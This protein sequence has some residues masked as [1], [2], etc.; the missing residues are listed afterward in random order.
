MQIFFRKQS[1][2]WLVVLVFSGGFFASAYAQTSQDS[3]TPT[4]EDVLKVRV[5]GQERRRLT[6][7]VQWQILDLA[8]Q[9][10]GR[11]YDLA[12][13]EHTRRPYGAAKQLQELGDEG[14]VIW[15]GAIPRREETMRA[16]YIPN[17]SGLVSYWNFFVHEEN[18]Q[19]LA[20]AETLDDLKDYAFLLG[21][22]FQVTPFIE[23]EGIEVRFGDA[24]NVPR[25]LAS[26]RADIFMYPAIFRETLDR[27]GADEFDMVHLPNVMLHLPMAFYFFVAQTGSEELHSAI[28]TGMTNAKLDGSYETLLSTHPFTR[29][30]F[31]EIMNGDYSLIEF[32]NP[33]LTEE[34]RN[35]LEANRK[36]LGR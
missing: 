5:L 31:N 11:N 24:S 2:F 9:K 25:M 28:S 12:L 19:R 27:F 20:H 3:T 17:L 13:S 4:D 7:T 23:A 35:V 10:S 32:D 1:R 36:K 16:V 22:D 18:L 26:G 15:R 30:S 21:E 6:E 29:D 14:N 34:T 33:N 8:L